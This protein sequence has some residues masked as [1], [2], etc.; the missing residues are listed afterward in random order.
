MGHSDAE[1]FSSFRITQA[2]VLTLSLALQ[3]SDQMARPNSAYS[4]GKKIS[5]TTIVSFSASPSS[6]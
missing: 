6:F 5:Q 3:L 4:K 2:T 1:I